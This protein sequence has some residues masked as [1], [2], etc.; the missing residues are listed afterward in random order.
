MAVDE[1]LL[2]GYTMERSAEA[3]TLRLYGWD[4]P[5]LSLGRG[6]EAESSSDPLYLRSEG[7]DRKI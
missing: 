2:L 5:A 7:I 6:Q 4:P 3:P 1:A